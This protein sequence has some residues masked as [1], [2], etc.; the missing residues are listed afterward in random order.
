[1]S[2]QVS[3]SSA[4]RLTE[5]NYKVWKLF[6]DALLRSKGL[7]KYVTEVLAEDASAEAGA[8]W[9]KEDG[10]A[11]AILTASLSEGQVQNIL[12]CTSAK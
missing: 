2:E 12:T 8:D 4:H 3:L 9:D 6:V 5:T 7:M 10:K 11:T 1:M